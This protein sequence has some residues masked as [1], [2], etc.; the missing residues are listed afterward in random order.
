M[1]MG[2]SITKKQV[3]I[4][5]FDY[6]R[7][8]GVIHDPDIRVNWTLKK[9]SN[10]EELFPISWIFFFYRSIIDNNFLSKL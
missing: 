5:F 7:K 6:K 1:I 10:I 3:K 4:R 2:L 9:P 8:K